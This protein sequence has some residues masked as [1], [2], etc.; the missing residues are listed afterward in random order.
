MCEAASE[1]KRDTEIV[2]VFCN[3]EKFFLFVVC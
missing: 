1:D 3:T 2:V